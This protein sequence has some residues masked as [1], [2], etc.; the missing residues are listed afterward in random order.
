[1]DLDD[2]LRSHHN[3]LH[4]HH[5]RPGAADGGSRYDA[6]NQVAL[7]V[8]PVAHPRKP[9]RPERRGVERPGY[10]LLPGERLPEV[11]PD[12]A[13]ADDVGENRALLHIPVAIGPAI[14]TGIGGGHV[15]PA[16]NVFAR[17][18]PRCGWSQDLKGRGGGVADIPDLPCPDLACP[19]RADAQAALLD[20]DGLPPDRV[21]RGGARWLALCRAQND[22]IRR[23]DAVGDLRVGV[24]I[25][26]HQALIRGHLEQMRL[27][28]HGPEIGG[29]DG[30]QVGGAGRL[31]RRRVVVERGDLP[32][33]LERGVTRG[34]RGGEKLAHLLG[35]EARLPERG[36]NDPA[37]LDHTAAQGGGLAAVAVR[38]G[39]MRE[40][41][42]EGDEQQH[43]CTYTTSNRVGGSLSDPGGDRRTSDNP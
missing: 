2:R 26:P 32:P 22:G 18:V 9:E 41:G 23:N 30:G 13:M 38:R 21:E 36:V 34:H 14:G 20:A 31:H 39:V 4:A 28:P 25:D 6:V 10:G 40:W 24:D 35:K 15:H 1:M 37:A 7:R 19:V 3:R 27:L 42:A 17:G 33:D 29:E 8:C 12:P 43:R 16:V 11:I 5:I